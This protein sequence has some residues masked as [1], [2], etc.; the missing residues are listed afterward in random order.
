MSER[1]VLAAVG[2][3]TTQPQGHGVGLTTYWLDPDRPNL[4]PYQQLSLEAPSYLAWHPVLPVLYVVHERSAGAVSALRAQRDGS[5]TLLA[6]LP[7]GGADPCHVAVAAQ[8]GLLLCSNYTSGSL[9]VFALD[10]DGLPGERIALV[11][12]IGG[13]PDPERQAG[14]HV[15]MSVPD[16]V[17]RVEVVDLGL[18]QVLEYPVARA[19][20]RS[21]IWTPSAGC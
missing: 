18:D 19:S 9:A 4:E 3:Y 14:P 6:T 11:Q 17:D 15:H 1:H 7:T 10:A 13:R 12:H 21:C 20:R 2:S 5:L 8:A 16:S